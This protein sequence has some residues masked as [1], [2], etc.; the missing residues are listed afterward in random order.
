MSKDNKLNKINKLVDTNFK[1]DTLDQ[2]MSD[3]FQKKLKK[4]FKT[5]KEKNTDETTTVS[6]N[7]YIQFCM[8]ERPNMKEEAKKDNP[9]ITAMEVTA[10]LGE[11]WNRLKEENPESLEKYGYKPKDESVMQKSVK[12]KKK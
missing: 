4:I 2:W 12:N 7:P 3:E 6:K 8:D 9:N 1:G 10:K 11:K 5:K